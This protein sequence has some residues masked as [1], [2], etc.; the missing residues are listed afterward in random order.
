VGPKAAKKLDE[1]G[2]ATVADLAAADL[3]ALL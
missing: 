2:L 1:L 3:E